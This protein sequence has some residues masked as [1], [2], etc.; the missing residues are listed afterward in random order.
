MFDAIERLCGLSTEVKVKVTNDIC[1]NLEYLDILF[2]IS[3]ANKEVIV[4]MIAEGRF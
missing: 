3:D 4:Q 1:L 2:S